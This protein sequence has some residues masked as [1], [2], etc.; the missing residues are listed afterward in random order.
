MLFVTLRDVTS[1]VFNLK[2]EICSYPATSHS[3]PLE[4]QIRS[5]NS[6]ANK[7]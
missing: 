6:F 4:Y 7:P 5:T 1:R 3:F 2:F